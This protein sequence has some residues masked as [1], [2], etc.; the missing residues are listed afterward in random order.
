[1]GFRG[2]NRSIDRLAALPF[3]CSLLYMGVAPPPRLTSSNFALRRGKSRSIAHL[4]HVP[5]APAAIT[6]TVSPSHRCSSSGRAVRAP[7]PRPAPS[8]Q[9]RG[10]DSTHGLRPLPLPCGKWRANSA[11]LD[12]SPLQ[13]MF[14]WRV[15]AERSAASPLSLTASSLASDCSVLLI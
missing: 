15:S 3:E 11:T 12:T 9:R 4:F 6:L 7:C 14:S 5:L 13:T 10:F 8:N 2:I 1:M